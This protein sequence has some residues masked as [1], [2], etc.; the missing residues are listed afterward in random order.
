MDLN[1][2]PL[3]NAIT[4]KMNWLNHKQ[5]V[6]A[7]NV[8]NA[9]TPDYRAMKLEPQD[10]S[11]LLAKAD[12]T[13][14]RGT[15]GAGPQR[16]AVTDPGHMTG[17]PSGTAATATEKRDKPWEAS[18]NGNNVILEEQMMDM[19]ETQME[20]GMLVN[21]YRKHVN[22]LRTSLGRSGR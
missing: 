7:Q 10:F 15:G 3:M 14:T 4:R 9:D 22:I 17:E 13:R 11:S 8:A 21:L 20:Y 1:D 5:R 19:A 16:M 18:P 12:R 2:I 6:I